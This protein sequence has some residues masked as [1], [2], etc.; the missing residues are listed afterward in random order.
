MNK[1][2]LAIISCTVILSGCATGSSYVEPTSQPVAT[3]QNY[4]LDNGLTNWDMARIVSIDNKNV[5]ASLSQELLGSD[6]KGD[7]ITI[8]PGQHTFV[9][10][11][12]FARSFFGGANEAYSEVTTTLAA[13]NHYKINEK[14]QD[15]H[16]LIW[17][18]NLNGH[19]TSPIVSEPFHT[20]T[21]QTVYMPVVTGRK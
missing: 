21:T 8:T 6:A 16:V 7:T 20:V 1:L 12:Q 18:A 3:I 4:N 13:N 9:V 10:Y 2:I 17:I 11:T 15:S 5:G 19:V 14:V